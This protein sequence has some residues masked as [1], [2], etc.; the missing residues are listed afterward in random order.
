MKTLHIA[1]G[2]S[3]GG[4]MMQAIRRAGLDDEVLPFLDDLSCGPID[5]HTPASRAT[6]WSSWHDSDEVDAADT[7]F[8]G[9]VTK[10]DQ[11]LIV[12]F[13]RHS[14]QELAFFLAWVDRLGDR[15]F[16]VIDV[17]GKQWPYTR[18]DGAAAMSRPAQA[19]GIIQP[20]DL[21][22][23]LGSERP[24]SSAENQ[25]AR[26]QWQTLRRENAHLRVLT[27]TGLASAPAD[28]FDPLII[29]CTTNEWQRVIHVVGEAMGRSWEPYLQ[30]GNVMLHQ[31][32]I[33]LVG[34]GKL[35]AE[36]DPR[37]ML[38]A[39]VRLPG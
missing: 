22:T 26:T 32:V 27:P 4:S 5:P 8:W 9:R 1:P 13:G 3:A 17:T 35:L 10:S 31:R 24:L 36:G 30:V 7:R 14:A 37:D 33:A 38:G 34:E 21:Q 15:P 20:W 29:E 28:Y 11:Q 12:W 18:K 2:D 23:L 6:W 39:R 19:V 16:G 25:E